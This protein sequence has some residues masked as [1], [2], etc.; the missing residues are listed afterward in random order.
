[1]SN[2]TFG[3]ADLPIHNG[4]RIGAF[5]IR[6]LKTKRV[7]RLRL[8]LKPE[9]IRANLGNPTPGA[10]AKAGVD[11]TTGVVDVTAF[12]STAVDQAGA[13]GRLIIDGTSYPVRTRG[14]EQLTHGIILARIC[15]EAD[16]LQPFNIAEALL[17]FD[18]KTCTIHTLPLQALR[19][20]LA[21]S[22]LRFLYPDLGHRFGR[23][24]ANL[25]SAIDEPS[26]RQSIGET[27]RTAT[28]GDAVGRPVAS[29]VIGAVK[30]LGPA[31]GDLPNC[32]LAIVE[33]IVPP[34]AVTALMAQIA[35]RWQEDEWTPVALGPQ[36]ESIFSFARPF[37][38]DDRLCDYAE[39]ALQGSALRP[40]ADA[41]ACARLFAAAAT[42]GLNKRID[43]LIL[44]SERIGVPPE[45]LVRELLLALGR[46][47]K[48]RTETQGMLHVPT[49]ELIKSFLIEWLTK[50]GVF[51]ALQESGSA[52]PNLQLVADNTSPRLLADHAVGSPASNP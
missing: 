35:Q 41:T 11:L 21:A 8:G 43:M 27:I 32:A 5:R 4:R 19:T 36:Y 31:A 23:A 44:V 6:T 33:Q 18:D 9:T 16:A 30:A 49:D 12:S 46:E 52:A 26:A 22:Y 42:L 45:E 37:Q 10:L 1:M 39:Q 48:L 38:N 7:A 50:H 40:G 3:I 25:F 17:S 24:V 14:H 29:A 13:D 28:D 15:E 47:T 2:R 20:R 34:A 51:R